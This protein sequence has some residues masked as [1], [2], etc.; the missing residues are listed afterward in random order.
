MKKNFPPMKLNT[1][2][3]IKQGATKEDVFV[4][5]TDNKHIKDVFKKNGIR[6][7]KE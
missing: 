2:R 6:F 3:I 1:T 5:E 4:V 7:P